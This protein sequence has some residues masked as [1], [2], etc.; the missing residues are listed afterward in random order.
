MEWVKIVAYT[1]L[2]AILYGI[3]H[4]QVTARI[5]VEYFTIFHPPVF[6]TDSPTLLVFGWGIIATWWMGV[7]LGLPLAFAARFGR[8][9]KRT[10]RSII[11]LIF[12]LLLAMACCAAIVGTTGYFFGRMPDYFTSLIPEGLY[13]RFLAAWWSHNASYLVGFIG[14]LILCIIVWRSRRLPMAKSQPQRE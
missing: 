14:A 5:C 2:A 9:P 8:R 6:G 4:D 11:P 3:V 1:I 13:R 10:A 12:R 7:G